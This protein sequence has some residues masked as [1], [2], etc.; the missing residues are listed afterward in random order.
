MG[1]SWRNSE[2]IKF[3]FFQDLSKAYGFTW[4]STLLRNRYIKSHL[5]LTCFR[6]F[7]SRQQLLHWIHRSRLVCKVP[8]NWALHFF[9]AMLKTLRISESFTRVVGIRLT[10]ESFVLCLQLTATLL[11]FRQNFSFETIHR[12]VVNVSQRSRNENEPTLLLLIAT[13]FIHSA[14]PSWCS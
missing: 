3:P 4:I 9:P 11:S 12:L 1:R 13:R 14:S 7:K 10:S 6:D 2:F 8:A 5:E